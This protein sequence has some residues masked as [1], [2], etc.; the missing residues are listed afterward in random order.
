MVL[1]RQVGR[2]ARTLVTPLEGGE[3]E[4]SM[5]GWAMSMVLVK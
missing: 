1:E 4:E 5:L 3:G 2:M